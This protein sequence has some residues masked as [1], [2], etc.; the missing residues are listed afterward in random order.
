MTDN[1]NMDELTSIVTEGMFGDGNPKENPQPTEQETKEQTED[2]PNAQVRLDKMRSQRDSERA[3]TTELERKL[4]E[5]EGKISVLDRDKTDDDQVDPTEYMSDTEKAMFERNQLLEKQ[6][7]KLANAVQGIQTDNT[8]RHLDDQEAQ[9][10]DRHPELKD[11]QKEVAEE[12][13]EYLKDQPKFVE[14][15]K[16][17]TMNLDQAYALYKVSNPQSTTK[18]QVA[19]PDAVFTG[20]T[21]SAAPAQESVLDMQSAMKKARNVLHDPNSTN[22]AQA[23][24]VLLQGIT[25]D[26]I[27]QFK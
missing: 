6:I 4:A 3:K 25:Q 2:I 11:N 1:V 20:S 12:M 10:F 14:M 9:F 24:D 27:S 13:V 17:G 21:E 15:L 8:K 22:K 18:S 26:I 7:E 19:N 23:S 5:A 16:A